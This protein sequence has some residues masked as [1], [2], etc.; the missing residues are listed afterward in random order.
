MSQS[1]TVKIDI[2]ESD[3]PISTSIHWTQTTIDMTKFWMILFA[4]NFWG[5]ALKPLRRC[6]AD[7]IALGCNGC[8]HLCVQLERHQW[9]V[10]S[11][12]GSPYQTCPTFKLCLSLCSLYNP[13]PTLQVRLPC[14]EPNSECPSKYHRSRHSAQTASVVWKGEKSNCKLVWQCSSVHIG[15]TFLGSLAQPPEYAM[16]VAM[17]YFCGFSPCVRR[18]T[19]LFLVNNRFTNLK[20]SHPAGR[21]PLPLCHLTWAATPSALMAWNEFVSRA[22]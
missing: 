14:L 15:Y 2:D 12:M 11:I 9:T 20:E 19:W 10:D 18:K 16:P 1:R 17:I 3:R 4:V 8:I 7:P 21:N 5:I 6:T 22:W 13:V